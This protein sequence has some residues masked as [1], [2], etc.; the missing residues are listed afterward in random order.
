M[1]SDI[2]DRN[3]ATTVLNSNFKR[4]PWMRHVV[5]DV[6]TGPKLQAASQKIGKFTMEV[7]ER[8]NR[9]KGVDPAS[10]LGRLMV[11]CRSR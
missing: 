8:S 2:R 9:A 6:Y 7:I 3:G 11:R 5:D 1:L 4:R 10:P